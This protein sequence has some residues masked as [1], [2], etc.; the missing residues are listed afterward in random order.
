MGIRKER[1][2]IKA[3]DESG[4]FIGGW[5]ILTNQFIGVRNTII[6]TQPVGLKRSLIDD[7]SPL[8][9][10]VDSVLG[11]L[12]HFNNDIDDYTGYGNRIEQIISLNLKLNCDIDTFS[13][14]SQ[15]NDALDKNL[16]NYLKEHYSGF[17]CHSALYSYRARK[18]YNS[19]LEKITDVEDKNWAED[20]IARISLPTYNYISSEWVANMIF[21]AIHEK[22]PFSYDEYE[23][24][25][26]LQEW[27]DAIIAMNRKLETPHNLLTYHNILSWEYERL[28]DSYLDANLKEN[29]DLPWLYWEN[30]T[31]IAFPLLTAQAFRDEAE[32]QHNC[33]ARMYLEPAA[34]GDTHI[35]VVRKKNNP[36]ESL[37]T[38]EVYDNH[39]IR[40]FLLKYNERVSG[41]LFKLKQEYAKHL[42]SSLN[43]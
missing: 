7:D 38:C 12:R 20:V 31:Y 39:C 5:N 27:H 18:V 17:Y 6:K 23:F 2:I 34:K 15:D 42:S 16:V 35:V 3:Y 8:A 36:N 33:V 26:F 19:V 14:L 32:A 41:E 29:N 37:I 30:D 43:Q 13:N 22:I 28:K 25:S 24:V 10:S 9:K 4:R 40:Q 1:E 11:F 21:R